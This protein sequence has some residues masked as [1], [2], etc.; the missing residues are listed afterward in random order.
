[1]IRSV[2]VTFSSVGVSLIV[3]ATVYAAANIYA[4]LEAESGTRSGAVAAVA[5]SSASGNAAL[6]FG[7]S[8]SVT[9]DISATT[10]TFASSVTSAT[11]GQTICLASGN[12]GTWGGTNKAITITKQA[13]ATPVMAFDFRTGD[14]DFTLDGMQISSGN[15]SGNSG[16][17]ND[18]NNPR[19]ITI[20]GSTFTGAVNIEYLANANI[21]FDGNTHNNIDTNATCT[22]S[23]ARIWFSYGPAQSGVTIRNSTMDGG[24]TD[25][26]QAGAGFTAENNT[27]RNIKEKSQADCQHTD[28][29]QLYGATNTI[30]RGN[31][32]YN[33]ADGIVAYDGTAGNLI[34]NNV[35]DLV[36]GRW[37]IELYADNGST[38]RH[39]TLVYNTGCEYAAC[40]WV[41]LDHKTANPAG[42]NTVIENNILTGISMNNGSSASVN[43]NNMLR[44]G[45]TGTN[46]NGTPSYT[47]G[48]APTNYSGF[49]LNPGSPGK[50]AGS[51]GFDVGIR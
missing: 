40:G 47:G 48:T 10:T 21:I 16:N 17:Y 19:N 44:S 18:T 23:P 5:D 41:V 29:I 36:T 33:S 1:M 30:I 9:C 7:D 45:A 13:G 32:I 26:I 11:A 12:Y 2:F 8:S 42:V 20:R 39:N 46:F 22:A 24:N 37:G 35:I 4:S 14:K 38:I 31:Y 25:G 6:K 15:I 34:E 43:R 28:S 3:A 27:F 49:Y 50:G 51:D